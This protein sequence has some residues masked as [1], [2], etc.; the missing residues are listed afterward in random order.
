MVSP[1][2]EKAP[3]AAAPAEIACGGGSSLG[4][5]HGLEEED[6]EGLLAPPGEVQ[7]PGHGGGGEAHR[8]LAPA[9]L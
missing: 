3:P 9:T 1:C 6:L 2:L 5:L 8:R 7:R 4:L